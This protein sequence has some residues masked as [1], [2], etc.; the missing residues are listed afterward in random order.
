MGKA[1]RAIIIEGDKILVMH[2]HKHG[3]EYFTLVGGRTNGEETPE[4]ALV[5]EVREETGMD[6][7]SARLVFVEEHAAPSNEQYIFLCTVAPHQDIAVQ[8]T[9]E[10]AF[11]NRLD[12]N[13]HKPLWVEANA[14]ARLYFRTPQLQEAIVKGLKKGFP[15]EPVKL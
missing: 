11:M 1:A 3:S 8:D 15:A 13:I 14:F 12:A 5:R 4:Q 6:I 9:S 7:A 2:R 10:E